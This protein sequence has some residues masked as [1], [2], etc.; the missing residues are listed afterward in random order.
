MTELEKFILGMTTGGLIT[1]C[2]VLIYFMRLLKEKLF[3]LET[4]IS[5][6]EEHSDYNYEALSKE[7]IKQ[8]KKEIEDENTPRS[9]SW[10]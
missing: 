3:L 9:Q 4:R 5:L 7:L 6:L 1:L 2:A 10:E 8:V